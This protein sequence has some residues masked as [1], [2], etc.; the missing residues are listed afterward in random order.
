MLLILSLKKHRLTIFEFIVKIIN[1]ENKSRASLRIISPTFSD[2]SKWI[3][4]IFIGSNSWKCSQ[5]KWQDLRVSN[6]Q[7]LPRWSM[8]IGSPKILH[9]TIGLRKKRIT[10]LD[11]QMLENLDFPIQWMFLSMAQTWPNPILI[12]TYSGD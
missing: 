11:F 12:Y 8:S 4:T 1:H 6:G 10:F 9:V 5:L 2:W 7:N 3:R